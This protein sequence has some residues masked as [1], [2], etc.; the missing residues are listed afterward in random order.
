MWAII[1][2]SIFVDEQNIRARSWTRQHADKSGAGVDGVVSVDL[3][4]R[5]RELSQQGTLRALSREGL[6][7]VI[8]QIESLAG[9]GEITIR[10]ERGQVYSHLRMDQFEA[11]YIFF[12]GVGVCCEFTARYCQLGKDV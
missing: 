3:G 2:E 12:A 5:T 10:T 8:D 9:T 6:Q 11:G 1:N 7:K 4:R